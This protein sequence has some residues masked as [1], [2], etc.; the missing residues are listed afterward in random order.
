MSLNIVSE[1]YNA[2]PS[3]YANAGDW[4]DCEVQFFSR[5]DYESEDLQRLVYKS[6]AGQYWLEISVGDDWTNYG[7]AVGQNI[8]LQTTW[9]YWDIVAP[10]A[11]TAPQ[12]WNVVITYITGNKMYIDQALIAIPNGGKRN[13]REAGRLKAQGVKAGVSDLLLPFSSQGAHGLWI[14]MKAGRNKLTPNQA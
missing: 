7:F 12:T 8:E 4:L 3:L 11:E 14:E 5:T 6:V 9:Y 10:G 2:L 13:P 1:T